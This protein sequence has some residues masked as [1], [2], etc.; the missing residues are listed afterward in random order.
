M[1][2]LKE[3]TDGESEDL[4]TAKRTARNFSRAVTN[5]RTVESCPFYGIIPHQ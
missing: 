2:Q 4:P 1:E 3:N 5:D